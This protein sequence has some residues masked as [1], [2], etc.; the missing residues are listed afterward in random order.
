VDG[1]LEQF[2]LFLNKDRIMVGF[3][4]Y[5]VVAMQNVELRRRA[6]FFEEV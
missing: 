6:N 4:S 1:N 3:S 2:G 5:S